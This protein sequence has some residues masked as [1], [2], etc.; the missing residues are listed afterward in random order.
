M[1][2]TSES[3]TESIRQSPNFNN[4]SFQNLSETPMKPADVS[5]FKI[6]KDSLNRPKDSRPGGIIP[7]IKTDLKAL[8]SE[9]PVIVWFGHSSYLIHVNGINILVDP[10]FSGH[11][12]PLSFMVKAFRGSD[13]YTP[14]DL[15]PIDI[16]VITHNHYDHLDKETIKRLIP[17]TKT[18]YTALGVSAHLEEYGMN[19]QPVIEMD[20][21][22]TEK[23]SPAIQLTATPARHFSGRGLKRGGTLWTSFVL[24]IAGYTLYIGGDSG[25]DTHFKK[26]GEQFGPF[27]L[28]ILECGQYNAYWPYIHM[29][30]EQTVQASLDLGAKK[31]LPV[32]WGKFALALHP[33]NEPI[34]RV[35]R[36]AAERNMP[37]MTPLIGEPIAIDESYPHSTWWDF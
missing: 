37:I 27:D 11:A 6:L 15:P 10:V 9:K 13:A 18:C 24:Q 31:L 34:K 35:T 21:W 3:R 5:Y 12:S 16:L 23:I 20:W 36:S 29:M 33:W 7:S 14:E 4:G 1:P 32:H 19:T 8:H 28:A 30:P 2:T 26:I 25:Y 22:D 17:T